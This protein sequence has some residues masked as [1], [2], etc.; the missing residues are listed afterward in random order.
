MSTDKTAVEAVMHA[1]SEFKNAN[2]ENLKQRDALLEAKIENASN[3]LDKFEPINQKLVLA[4]QQANAMQEQLDRIEELHNRPLN[5]V[6]KDQGAKIINAFDRVM[7]RP[8]A[9]RDREDIETINKY[10]A[11]LIKSDDVSAGYLLAPPEMDAS[12]V[13]KVIEMTPMRVLATVRIIGSGSLKQPRKNTSG[14]ASRVGEVQT[15][16]NTGDP[17]Y[18]MIEIQAP[19]MYAR[20][21]IGAQMLEDSGYD[22]LAELREDASEQFSVKEGLE[23]ISGLGAANQG[24]GV[25]TNADIAY[26]ASGVAAAITADGLHDLIYSIKT[27]YSANGV[28]GMNRSTLGAI[29]KLK[30]GAGNYLWIPGIA[31]ASPNTI[32]GVRYVEMPDMPNIAAGTFPVIYGDFKRGYKIVDRIGISFQVDFNTEADNGLVIFRA[33]KRSGSGVVL[34]EAIRKLKIAVS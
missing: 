20:I 30:D 1:F 18:G 29:R 2:D 21:A 8:A 34:P 23:Y 5:G 13:K 22:L 31:N 27:A 28:M 19:E 26:T 10:S 15:R 17:G 25:L 12:I 9:E 7:R 14:S 33:R 16:T 32:D 3:A 24:E 11:S 4:E 6:P